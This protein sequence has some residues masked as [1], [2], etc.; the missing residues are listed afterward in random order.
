MIKTI[1]TIA[2]VLMLSGCI[3][4]DTTYVCPEDGSKIVLRPDHTYTVM[5]T[6]GSTHSGTYNIIDEKLILNYLVLGTSGSFV[7]SIEN[8][9]L[10]EQTGCRW[11]KV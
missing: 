6:G 2:I 3:A 5:L 11:Y 7:L 10:T 9:S 1:A 4:H 8:E